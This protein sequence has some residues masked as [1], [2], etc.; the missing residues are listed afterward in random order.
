MELFIDSEFRSLI[1]PLAPEELSMLEQSVLEEG[2]RDAIITW[3]GYIVDGHNRYDII[4]RH[5]IKDYR[6]ITKQF[7]DKEAAK[8]WIMRNQISRRN[9]APFLRAEYIFKVNEWED[10]Q[11]NKNRGGR[12]NFVPIDTKFDAKKILAE[13]LNIGTNTASRIIQIHEKAPEA[14]K[15]KL[16]KGEATINQVY[17]TLKREEVKESVKTAEWP[18]GKYRIIY[19]DPPWQYSNSMP[20]DGDK[21]GH[22]CEQVDHYTLMSLE[23]IANLPVRDLALENS[24]LFLWSTSPILEDAF[25]VIN[26]WG[27][28]YKSSFIWDK[29]KHNMGHFNSVRHELLLIATRGSCQPDNIELIDSVQSIERNGHSEK[30]ELFREIIQK[31]YPFGP[32]IELFARRKVEGWEVYG[33]Q[34]CA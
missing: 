9:V 24:V 12:G 15:E 25:K 31:L 5:G 11:R 21:T 17:V 20:V 2:V 13:K 14:L 19:A 1:P 10:A 7:P 33:N 8:I 30:P 27:F 28:K 4:T 3:N 32:R 34:I 18:S 16:R 26:A 29:V 22:F 6:V 23:D